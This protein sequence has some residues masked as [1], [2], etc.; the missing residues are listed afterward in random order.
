MKCKTPEQVIAH[1]ARLAALREVLSEIAA[2]DIYHHDP[3]GVDELKDA[4][5]IK[6]AAFEIVRDKIKREEGGGE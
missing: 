2:I 4:V 1:D 5:Q 6:G 3:L